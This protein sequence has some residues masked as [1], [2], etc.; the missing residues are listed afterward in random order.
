MSL[1]VIASNP[2]CRVDQGA[3]G[4]ET[5]GGWV[6]GIAHVALGGDGLCAAQTP[7]TVSNDGAASLSTRSMIGCDMG[8]LPCSHSHFSLHRRTSS[9]LPLRDITNFQ[10]RGND[11]LNGVD[12]IVGPGQQLRTKRRFD[13]LP[14]KGT[15][16][17]SR[18]EHCREL[19]ASIGDRGD[20]GERNL[21]HVGKAF[22][23][24]VDARS[25]SATDRVVE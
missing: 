14:L 22:G 20:G 21:E 18:R 6:A 10:V 4:T 13:M 19:P 1:L 9:T 2:K 15:L 16:R 5:N 3:D 7:A 24:V 12:S 25:Y 23:C 11:L 8:F 17:S